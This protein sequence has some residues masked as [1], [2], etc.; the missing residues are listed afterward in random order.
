MTIK[1]VHVDIEVR[2]ELDDEHDDQEGVGKSEIDSASSSDG[3][4]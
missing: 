2:D 4:T 3:D 1:K